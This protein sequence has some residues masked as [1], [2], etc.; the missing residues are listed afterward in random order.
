[1]FA[2]PGGYS[3]PTD[4]IDIVLAGPG[5]ITMNNA[6]SITFQL[7]VSNMFAYATATIFVEPVGLLLRLLTTVVDV[8]RNGPRLA[9]ARAP[10]RPGGDSVTHLGYD[11]RTGEILQRHDAVAVRGVRLPEEAELARVS[12][13]LFSGSPLASEH[14]A[15]TSVHGQALN[16]GDQIPIDQKT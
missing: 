16:V 2:F 9:L 5:S 14:L 7:G 1:M 10:D 13:R 3:G 11:R 4:T 15:I 6:H 8:V 12:A